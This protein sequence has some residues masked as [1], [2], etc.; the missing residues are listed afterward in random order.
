MI[1]PTMSTQKPNSLYQTM[2]TQFEGENHIISVTSF[3]RCSSSQFNGFGFLITIFNVDAIFLVRL[4]FRVF[5]SAIVAIPRKRNNEK[6]RSRSEEGY[7]VCRFRPLCLQILQ[8]R[9]LCLPF[10]PFVHLCTKVTLQ[11]FFYYFTKSLFFLTK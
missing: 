9:P 8:F 5:D 4:A 10:S 3:C 11:I 6:K 2:R 1:I 7:C